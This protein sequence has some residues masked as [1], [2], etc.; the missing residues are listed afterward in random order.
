MLALE[1]L[2]ALLR[3]DFICVIIMIME[4]AAANSLPIDERES[5]VFIS[6]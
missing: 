5:E 3:K 6:P 4:I 1:Q 2:H